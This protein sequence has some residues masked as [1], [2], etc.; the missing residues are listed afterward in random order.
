[1]FTNSKE[2][3][4]LIEALSRQLVEQIAPEEMEVFDDLYQEAAANSFQPAKKKGEDDALGFGVAEIM[5]AVTPVAGTVI[6]AVI[7]FL[8]SEV[9]KVTKDEASAVIQ[10]KVKAL[11]N[12]KKQDGVEPLTQAQL[13]QVKKLAVKLARQSGMKEEEAD[14][15]AL[16]LV[17]SLALQK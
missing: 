16:T 15:L 8:A 4:E 2:G 12:P 6:S 13:G 10:K 11:F 9:L 3:R 14:R 5:I 1:M 7:S 17:G